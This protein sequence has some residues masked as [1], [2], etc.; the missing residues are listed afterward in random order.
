MAGLFGAFLVVLAAGGTLAAL[1]P[2]LND[3]GQS[4]VKYI[5]GIYGKRSSN[6]STDRR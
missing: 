3:I 6:T 5:R 1:F 4:I 2:V